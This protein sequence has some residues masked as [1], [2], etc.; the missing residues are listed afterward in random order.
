MDFYSQ[1]YTNSLSNQNI[2][3]ALLV[4]TITLT[5]RIRKL[6]I[7]VDLDQVAGNGDYVAY[8]TIQRAGA[9]S[10]YE[11]IRAT[12]SAA[13]GVTAI[14]FGS[15]AVVPNS[16]TD[17]IKV[18]V[19]GLAGD[20]TTPDIVVTALEELPALAGDQMD[21]VNAPNATAITAIQNGL[22]LAAT[23]TL[24]K[25][26]TDN[27]PTDPADQ[28]DLVTLLNQIIAYVDTEVQ[29]IKTVTDKM[30]F[31]ASNYV[32]STPQ[33][34]VDLSAGAIADVVSAAS[35][36]AVTVNSSIS[37]GV[38]EAEDMEEGVLS[39]RTNYKFAQGIDTTSTE[40]LLNARHVFAVKHAVDD[41][42][43][44]A[45]ILIDSVDGL[46]RLNGAAYGDAADGE[47][48][49][50]GTS[51]NWNVGFVVYAAATSQLEADDN[52]V[53][54]D[55]A[56]VG[57]EPILVGYGKFRIRTGIVKEI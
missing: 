53:F 30:L 36:S 9:G 28:S 11:T 2:S 54:E 1:F 8:L 21:L 51:G 35:G 52:L 37:I 46:L 39:V 6:V 14:T 32:K 17:V 12:K 20:T 50:S 44:D 24:V 49:V 10:A 33:T 47:I 43:D 40:D 42:D 4:G 25:A 23:L 16:A 3:S 41:V 5:T 31:D 56:F 45:V 7:N 18:Y 55:K 22:A 29:A 19:V 13:S 26:K 57:T 27:L 48:N 15:I 38:V 34:D